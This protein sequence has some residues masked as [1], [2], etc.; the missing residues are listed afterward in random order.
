M[1]GRSKLHAK[2]KR[3]KERER[4]REREREEERGRERKREEERKVNKQTASRYS[5]KT[6]VTD[7]RNAESSS[8]EVRGNSGE[9]S[10]YVRMISGLCSMCNKLI[11]AGT[12]CSIGKLAIESS[13]AIDR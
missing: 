4:E 13:V 3:Q 8:V 11:K 12:N 6:A 1:H 9:Y 5:N 2:K 10:S 7:E